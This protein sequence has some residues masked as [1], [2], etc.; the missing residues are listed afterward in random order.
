MNVD[1][2]IAKILAYEKLPSIYKL[3]KFMNSYRK[4]KNGNYLECDCSGLIKGTL[5]GYPYHGKYRIFIRMLTLIRL[6]LIIVIINLV[7]LI[8]FLEGSLYG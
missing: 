2:F 8:I 1:E 4:G 7:I 6:C 3:G 5:W